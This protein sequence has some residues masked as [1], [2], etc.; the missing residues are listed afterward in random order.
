MSTIPT[1]TPPIP[2]V[3]ELAKSLREAGVAFC[4]WKSN[5]AIALAEQGLTDL[6][7][8][9]SSEDQERFRDVL[10]GLG[11]VPAHRSGMAPIPGVTH[12]FGYD[13][14]ADRFVHVHA[15]TQLVLG[16]DRTKNY[17]IPVE[18]AYLASVSVDRALPIPSAEFEYIVLVIRMVLKYAIVDEILWAALRGR[19]SGPERSERV[20]F[21]DLTAAIDR[22]RVTE[23]LPQHFPFVDEA[24]FEAAEAFVAGSAGLQ[25]TIAAGRQMQI[26][27]EPY[28][29]TGRWM[30]AFLRVWRRIQ[31]ALRRRTGRKRKFRLESGGSIIAIMGGDGAG[32]ST[33]LGELDEWLGDHFDVHLIHLGKPPW[34]RT[35]YL[36]R[37]GL[38]IA[39]AIP[40]VGSAPQDGEGAGTVSGTRRYI[41]FACK[42]RDRYLE[43]RRARRL[44]EEGYMVISDRFPH[45]A[46]ELMDVPQIDRLSRDGSPGRFV[47][48]LTGVENRY[49]ARVGEPDLA[50]V[51]R[52]HPEEA[53]RR[54]TD[55]PYDYVVR[56]ATEIW[57]IDWTTSGVHV[58][59]AGQAPETVAA[60]LKE[61]IWE[62]LTS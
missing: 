41:W 1:N 10:D 17:T 50:A 32:K 8:L 48:W 55:E 26:A 49:H 35:T 6:D 30:D 12:L 53:G 11:F 29:R 46:L 39:A 9:V 28:A 40:G 19:R 25:Q 61:L 42:A 14:T 38:K 33:A 44:A 23:I 3:S 16:H 52:V 7:L 18:D 58:I 24:L 51:L 60:E 45:P 4:H 13:V 22:G 37:G 59:D 57:S 34:S 36:I 27:L 56:R 54:K 21:D 2:L 5:A 62:S 15:H 31:V 43:Y 47:Q 20:E